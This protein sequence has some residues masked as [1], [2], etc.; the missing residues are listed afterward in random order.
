[1]NNNNSIQF[2]TLF[3]ADYIIEHCLGCRLCFDR[4]EDMCPL[5]DDLPAIK[6]KIKEAEAVI[7]ASPV[8][9]GDVNSNMKV[10]IDRLAYISHRPEFYDKLGLIIATTGGSQTRHTIRTLGGALYSWGVSVVGTK[11]FR[12]YA[13]TPMEELD[14]IYGKNLHRLAEK[15]YTAIMKKKHLNPTIFNLAIFMLRQK[16]WRKE[17]ISSYDYHYYSKQGWIN[18]HQTFYFKHSANSLKVLSAKII[19]KFLDWI[20]I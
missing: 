7:F 18:Q 12:T 3:L 14:K 6:L 20:F 13:N 19:C 11:G 10:L 9:V 17:E 4:G 5:K 2:E 15:F 1:M 8:Y 16:Y